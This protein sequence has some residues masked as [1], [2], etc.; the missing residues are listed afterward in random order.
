MSRNITREPNYRAQAVH[1]VLRYGVSADSHICN[2]ESGIL[3][4]RK[5]AVYLS[6]FVSEAHFLHVGFV[7][8]KKAH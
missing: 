8:R 2:V 1:I 3:D 4:L 5:K 6:S 7:G